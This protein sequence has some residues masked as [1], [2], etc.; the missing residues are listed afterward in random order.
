MVGIF[1]NYFCLLPIVVCF[2]TKAQNIALLCNFNEH[3]AWIAFAYF[4]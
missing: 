1:Y 4:G 3:K 2:R